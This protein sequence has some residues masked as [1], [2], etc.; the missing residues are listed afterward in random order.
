MSRLTPEQKSEIMLSNIDTSDCGVIAI[1]AVAG[2]GR[3]EAEKVAMNFGYRPGHGTPRGGIDSA[4]RSLGY[5]VESVEID[6]G[7]TAATF[8]V[9]ND[10]GRFLVYTDGH[11]MGLVEGNLTNS[12]G[13][14]RERVEAVKRVSK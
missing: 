10:Y 4:V 13:Q 11:V 12:R 6:P 14:W 5:R 9:T 3:A 1:Q 8:A 2:I 7:E